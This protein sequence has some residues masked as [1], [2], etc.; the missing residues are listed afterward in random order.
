MRKKCFI[1]IEEMMK[2]ANQKLI[3]YFLHEKKIKYIG[4][5]NYIELS[6]VQN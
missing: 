2:T 3:K 4:L 1:G 5:M 6:I